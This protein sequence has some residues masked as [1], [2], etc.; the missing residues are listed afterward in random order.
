MS[1]KTFRGGVHPDGHKELSKG[2]PVEAFLPKGDMVFPLSQHIGKPAKPIVK[3]GDS[4][5]AGQL[6][7]EADG[8][9]SANI[10][11][12]C[13]GTVKAVE[14]RHLGTGGRAMCIVIENDGQFTPAPGVGVERDP[15]S[16]SNE[17]IL[18]AIKAAGIVGLGGAGFPTHVKLAP[19]NPEDIEYIIANG[20]E[21][22]PYIT[23]DDQL[24][25]REAKGIVTGI[26]LL[27][28]LFPNAVGV[29]AVED[30]KPEA[31]ETLKG[32]CNG[33]KGI[34]VMPVMAKYPEGG[35]RSLIGVVT[36]RQ[37]RFGQLPA[38]LGC[39]VCNVA[40]LN[41]IY[42][43]ACKSEPL[44]ERLFTVSGDAVASPR[45]MSVRI[46]TSCTEVLEA[47]G[48]IKPGVEVKKAVFGGPMMGV[49]L[50]TLDTPVCKNNNALTV[51][52][53]DEVELAE[54]QMTACIRCGRCGQVCPIGLV[55]QMM[56]EA[57]ER[58]D[59]E[60][61]EKKLYGLDCIACGTCT[62]ICPAKRPLMQL[63]KQTKAAIMASKRK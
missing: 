48:G 31:I 39:V 5:L 24:M 14:E 2:T 27:M 57:A 40:S 26:K 50:T 15:D 49:P 11:S 23:C 7:A 20:S 33:E 55:P 13:S 8:F 29:I 44:M 63:F 53:E 60:R 21:C 12:S 58:K 3:K 51:L 6:I 35:E 42:R 61:Y 1:H 16:L 56:A 30:N 22:E 17:E 4:V 38:E 28:Q 34:T 62:Y 19:R 54:E 43:A 52:A 59:F 25:Q 10:V 47:A 9:V 41:A 32:V 45:T 36:G 18:A 46:G 37:L